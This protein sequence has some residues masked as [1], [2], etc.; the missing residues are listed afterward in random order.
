VTHVSVWETDSA[1]ARYSKTW[2]SIKLGPSINRLP[3]KYRAKTTTK[4]C[5]N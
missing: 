1:N 5:L 4:S 2:Y 3:Y